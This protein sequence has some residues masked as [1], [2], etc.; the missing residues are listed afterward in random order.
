MKVPSTGHNAY[1]RNFNG[2]ALTS[3]YVMG[4]VPPSA[5]RGEQGVGSRCDRLMACAVSIAQQGLTTH[6]KQSS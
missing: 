2:F 1:A 6:A 4:A 3:A 5:A